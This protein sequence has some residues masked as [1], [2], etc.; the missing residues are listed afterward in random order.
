[1]NLSIVAVERIRMKAWIEVERIAVVDAEGFFR[2]VRIES[3]GIG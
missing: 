2:I 1:M 3:L